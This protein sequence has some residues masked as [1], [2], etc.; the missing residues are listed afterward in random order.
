MTTFCDNMLWNDTATS[1]VNDEKHGVYLGELNKIGPH[2]W[3]ILA[4]KDFQGLLQ[5]T[6]VIHPKKKIGGLQLSV[7]RQRNDL[8]VVN[9]R[10]GA[11]RPFVNHQGYLFELVK[12]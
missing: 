2:N 9:Y 11:W 10:R 3:D 12:F 7:D 6:R 8:V 4:D 1:E 5:Q